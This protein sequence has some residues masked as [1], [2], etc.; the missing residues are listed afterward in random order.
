MRTQKSPHPIPGLEVTELY[1]ATG[2]SALT[3]AL[4]LNLFKP[5]GP[6][7]APRHN[8]TTTASQRNADEQRH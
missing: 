2:F 3:E 5:A 4:L 7:A 8:L 6:A 1:G